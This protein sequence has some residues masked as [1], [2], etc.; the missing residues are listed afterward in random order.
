M[1]VN[2]YSPPP[3]PPPHI[4]RPSAPPPPQPS[5]SYGSEHT[6]TETQPPQ[7]QIMNHENTLLNE[8][9]QQQQ[10]Q[11]QEQYEPLST[12]SPMYMIPPSQQQQQSI[13]SP[14][15]QQ[16]LYPQPFPP[17][18]QLYP[19]TNSYDINDK[20]ISSP[21]STNPIHHHHNHNHQ[22]PPQ[23]RSTFPSFTFPPPPPL[24]QQQQHSYPNAT[25]F[26]PINE[27]Q[28]DLVMMPVRI[29]PPNNYQT[30]LAPKR[31]RRRYNTMKRKI[32]LTDGNLV[33]D[34]PI[35]DQ[36]L[37]R[38]NIKTG[39][40]FTHMRYTAITNDPSDFGT[41]KLRQ[42]LMGRST[43]LFICITMYN[44]DEIL[45][46]N[47]LYNVMK[48]IN[49][50]CKRNRSKTWGTNSW[51]K[52]VVCIIADG[53]EKVHPRVLD[54]LSTLGIY[55]DG[56]AKNIVN[57]K[58][59]QAHLYEYTTQMAMDP[60]LK[61]K[62]PENNIV[63]TQ[64]M[65][66]IKEKNQR[67]INSHR[68]F[69]QA[70][71]P[72]L[73]PNV[74]MLFD[75]G[76]RPGP[77][78]IYH[79]WKNFDIH[80]NVGG[81]C[82]EI[83]VMKGIGGYQLL[84]PLVAAQNFEYKISNILDKPLESVFGYISVL[85]GAF[86]AYRYNA[87]QNDING[88]GPLEKYFLG[89]QMHDDDAD[90]FDANM[91]LA[92]DRIL[93][94]ELVAKKR[95][96]WTLH[97]VSSA[98]GETDVPNSIPEFISQRRRWIN[99]SFFAGLYALYHW[100][101]IFRTEHST[102]R[103]F[104]LL[105]ELIYLSIQWVFSWFALGNYFLSF[106]ILTRSLVNMDN[107]P[108]SENIASAFF[109]TLVYIYGVLLMVTAILSLGNRPQG[110]SYAY[111]IIF[112]L[113]ALIMI[114]A[115]FAS[116]WIA[117]QAIRTG[118]ESSSNISSLVFEGGPFRDIIISVAATYAIYLISSIIFFDPWHMITSFVQYL[119]MSPSYI[120]ILNCFAFCNTH[121]VSWG[122]KDLDTVAFDL[123]V[124]ETKNGHSADVAVPEHK[125]VG[126]LYEEALQSLDKKN[127]KEKSHRDPRTKQEDYY[128]SVRTRLVTIWVI[129]NLA[130]VGGICTAETFGR[131]GAFNPTTT[132][133]YMAFLLWAVAGLSAFRFLGCV[134]YRII[135]I[136]TG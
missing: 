86:S 116:I 125:D 123:G 130:L 128:R 20:D 71:C 134:S 70:F 30:H 100:G 110:S 16:Q 88:H 42:S 40:E 5:S 41:Y 6:P 76:T 119:L 18:V 78:S 4:E 25:Y 7:Q 22:H 47:T 79:L 133:S 90:I 98:Y 51:E 23:H 74:C 67:K 99:G 13:P 29:S 50:L 59:V 103:K 92:E 109:I 60:N 9:Q 56:V 115:M 75:V 3:P 33:L 80:A 69:F 129:S 1:R 101:N 126:L 37:N 108:F 91:Y 131:L 112:V 17:F 26:Y 113:F 106:Y 64:V 124:V 45:L 102:G 68:W 72:I 107:P 43:E 11:Q 136:F 66:C 117:Y 93:C 58:P 15:P 87:L 105:I 27:N 36:Y 95:A 44:E 132:N 52:I 85:P 81:A 57:Y 118:L 121:D 46:S 48:N 96:N 38:V 73:K 12:Q 8:Q 63:P 31:Q 135:S 62:G 97:Y 122:T 54:M 104:L 94:F 111:T 28:P 35:P 32:K 84:N 127:N 19:Y 34:C 21:S 77:Q 53:R 55:Q 14:P 83:R 24:S 89:E 61:L 10:Q 114:Y 39:K 120:N 49:N 2:I 65:L 82:G